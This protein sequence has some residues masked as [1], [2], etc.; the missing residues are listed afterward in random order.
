MDGHP[1]N[2]T[3]ILKIA[4]KNNLYVIEDVAQAIGGKYLGKA[5]G[6]IGDVGCFSFNVNKTIS[7]GEG[8]AIITNDRGHYEK[9]LCTQDACSL[10]GSTHKESFTSITP[11]IGQSMRVSEI[12]GALM[13]IQLSRLDLILETLKERKNIFKN[14]FKEAGLPVVDSWDEEGDCGSSLY[15]T[16]NSV[17]ELNSK[18]Q[19]MNI[20]KAWALPVTARP[21]HVCWQWMHLLAEVR[22]KSLY[23]KF[24]FLNSIDIISRTAKL[25]IPFE[26]SIEETNE[27]ACDLVRK[28]KA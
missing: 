24:N 11:F 20:D 4:Q 9:S 21:A 14:A 22:P 12:T 25:D 2:M 16:F 10:F 8:G 13:C 23:T 3:E 5:L 15:L 26:L 17:E 7:A 1:C 6:S 27:L 28:L 18:L 19:K